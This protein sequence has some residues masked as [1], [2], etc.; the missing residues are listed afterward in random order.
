MLNW[1]IG[2]IMILGIMIPI[3]K[4]ITK[5]N[6]KREERDVWSQIR[7]VRRGAC[8]KLKEMLFGC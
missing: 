8:K 4:T 1:I 6:R 5:K 2:V 7:M 3:I